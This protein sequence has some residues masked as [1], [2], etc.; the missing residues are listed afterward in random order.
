[1]PNTPLPRPTIAGQRVR[2]VGLVPLSLAV[3]VLIAPPQATAKPKT[4]LCRIESGGS[5]KYNGRCRFTPERGGSFTIG[6]VRGQGP[7]YRG[8]LVISVSIIR[9]GV[10][11]VRGLTGAGINSRWGRAVRSRRNPACWVGSDFRICVK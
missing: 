6:P 1:M 9:R 7:L 2:L 5:L 4:A 10:A 3:A 11:E 8:V